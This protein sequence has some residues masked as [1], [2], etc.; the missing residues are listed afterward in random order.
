MKYHYLLLFVSILYFLPSSSQ[1][2]YDFGFERNNSIV[3]KDSLGNN[4]SM[5]WAGG[6]NAAHF[7]E[8]DINRDGIMDM[9]SFDTHGDRLMT[10]I[11]SGVAGTSS[12]TYEPKYE[13]EFPKCYSWLQTY[14]YDNDGKMDLFTYVP[15]GIRVF[16]NT[17]SGGNLQFT[18]VTYMLNYHAVSGYDVNIYVSSVDYPAFADVDFDGDMDILTFHVLGSFVIWYKNYSMETYGVPDSLE[19]KVADKCWGKFAENENNNAV[20]LNYYCNYKTDD[21]VKTIVPKSNIKHTGSTLLSINLNG[22]SLMDLLLGDV[23][24]FTINSLINGGSRDSALIVSQDTTF[25]DIAP[26]DIVTFPSMNYIDINNDSIKDLIVSPFDPSYYK[27]NARNGVWLYKNSGQNDNPNFALTE[28]GF[29]QNNM[30]DVGDGALPTIADVDGDGLMDLLVGN[31]GDV[32]STYM[33]S[34]WYLLEVYKISRITYYKNIGTASNPSFKYIDGNWLGLNSL[35]KQ[36]LKPT[37]GDL[38][39]DGDQDLLIG[40]S[41][42]KLVYKENIAGPNQAMVFGP[43]QYNYQGID[44]GKFST[45]QLID[46]D[47]DSLLDLVIGNKLGNIVYY[48]NTGSD[49]NAIFTHITDTMGHVKTSNYW[50]Y[51]NGYS[52]PNFY[53]D[54]DDSLRAFIGSAS[55]FCFYYKDIRQNVL[56][57]FGIDSNLLYADVVDTLYSLLSFTNEGNIIETSTTGFRSAPLVYDFDNDGLLDIMVGTFSGGI[58]YYKGIIRPYVG[59]SKTITYKMPEIRLYPNPTSTFFNIKIDDNQ[60]FNKTIVNIYD[61]SGRIVFQQLYNNANL[62]RVNS[63]NF[64]RGIYIVNVQ[65][66]NGN[67]QRSRTFKI[68]KY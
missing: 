20:Y 60:E 63:S 66:S 39:G 2:T 55:G 44:V 35:D 64:V 52:V 53:Y 9:V 47:G 24:Y 3:V 5:A 49:T 68:V 58:N 50:H 1:T 27:V 10:Y 4:L 17:S 32:D 21:S 38:D 12:Y 26:I 33:D 51:Y 7:Q 16:R 40:S 56:G 37:F 61:I 42:G 65:L 62:I 54:E 13:K 14:D 23:D 25:P 15:G 6:L 67:S 57:D 28:K 8:I 19:F 46:I 31:Y 36:S 34:V 29:M 11:N 43:N 45:P 41:D 22:D 30:I 48:K 18:Q 59:I